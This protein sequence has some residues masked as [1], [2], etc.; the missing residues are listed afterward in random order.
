M[1]YAEKALLKA[2]EILQMIQADN[3]KKKRLFTANQGD[4]A[5]LNIVKKDYQKA[6]QIHC[7]NV[8]FRKEMLEEEPE[9]D[10]KKMVAASYKGM[11][12][13]CGTA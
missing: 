4:L 13:A 8:A 9:Q 10:Y 2:S 11:A 1:E 6:F 5:A 12:T 7:D 3:K